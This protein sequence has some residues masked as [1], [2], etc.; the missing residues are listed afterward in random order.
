MISFFI[1]L[2]IFTF[3]YYV[4]QPFID[5][6]SDFVC[7]VPDVCTTD[8]IG[9]NYGDI[10]RIRSKNTTAGY[11]SP[12]GVNSVLDCGVAITLRPNEEFNKWEPDSKLRDWVIEGKSKGTPVHAEDTIQLRALATRWNG[13]TGYMSPCGWNKNTNCGVNVTLR[14]D[15]GFLEHEPGSNLRNWKIMG[16]HSNIRSGDIIQ[17][18]GLAT[19]WKGHADYLSVCG[20]AGA[21]GDNVV[22][23]PQNNK[24]YQEWIITKV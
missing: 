5:N 14:T 23:L 1:I 4:S 24:P 11:L 6:Y 20:N 17:I 10:V 2:L 21:C 13:H 22:L 18:K 16:L 19:K 12:C 9:I 3:I 15:K 7:D 8:D